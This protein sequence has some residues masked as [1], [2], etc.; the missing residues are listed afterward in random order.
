LKKTHGIVLGICGLALLLLF[1]SFFT[2]IVLNQGLKF[3]MAGVRTSLLELESMADNEKENIII[4]GNSTAQGISPSVVQEYLNTES[5]GENFKVSNFMFDG[6]QLSDCALFYPK[7]QNNVKVVIQTIYI[8]YLTELKKSDPTL[9]AF[10]MYNYTIDDDLKSILSEQFY[11]KLTEPKIIMGYEARGI[12]KRGAQQT[13]N[14]FLNDY[15]TSANRQNNPLKS[16]NYDELIGRKNSV[17]PLKNYKI[18]PECSSIIWKAHE[19]FKKRS[20]RYVLIID[21]VNPDITSS[22]EAE[23]E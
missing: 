4:F 3:D 23:I 12:I 9:V 8:P 20:I 10:S 5:G 18:D 1:L 19:Y 15:I 6:A 17:N 22:S 14:G 13:I 2:Q 21:P 16:N 7:T 11:A